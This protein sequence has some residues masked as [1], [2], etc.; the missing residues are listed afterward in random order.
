MSPILGGIIAAIIILVCVMYCVVQH[1]QNRDLKKQYTHTIKELTE[2]NE[3]KVLSIEK[4]F[5][6][7]EELSKKK[8]YYKDR[9]DQLEKS[10]ETGFGVTVRNEITIVETELLK[11]DYVIM[12]SGV[13]KLLQTNMKKIEDAEY[14]IGL[15][16]KIQAILDQMSEIQEEKGAS[17]I[18]NGI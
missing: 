9:V 12:L 18:K 8:S 4:L 10:I 3:Q 15:I 5:G 13:N 1:L 11:L 6:M 17:E 7:L 14:Y 16:K 2:S